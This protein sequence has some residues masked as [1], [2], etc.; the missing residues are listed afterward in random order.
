MNKLHWT[1]IVPRTL[2][3]KQ[4]IRI[5]LEFPLPLPLSHPCKLRKRY[6]KKH[7]YTIALRHWPKSHSSSR[8][9]LERSCFF[10][11]IGRRNFGYCYSIDR[12]GKDVKSKK[13]KKEKRRK[14]RLFK[15][16][17]LFHSKYWSTTLLSQIFAS[18][19]PREKKKK[20]QSPYGKTK[21]FYRERKKKQKKIE[22]EE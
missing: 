2:T 1:V 21:L 20:Y 6:S 7:F 22:R 19:G 3:S 9:S 12:D 8:L 4:N 16:E 13:K 15:L 14:R 11:S 10:R 17:T 5:R 18:R